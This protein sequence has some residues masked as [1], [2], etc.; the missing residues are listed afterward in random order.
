MALPLLCAVGFAP[1][2]KEKGAFTVSPSSL[3]WGEVDFSDHPDDMEEQGYDAQTVKVKNTGEESLDVILQSFDFDRLCLDGFSAAPVLVPTLDPG[4][5]YVF[6]VGVC[7]Y[8]A[9]DGD[10]DSVV[11]GS[12]DFE[13]VDLDG[14]Q[15]VSWSYTPT[16]DIDQDDSGGF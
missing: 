9:E 2:C 3:D 13:A 16:I 11:S 5:S 14:T 6:T 8:V 1:G 7:G 15:S 4:S 12:L 10:R